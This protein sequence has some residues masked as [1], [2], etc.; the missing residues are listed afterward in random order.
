MAAGPLTRFFRPAHWRLEG[1]AR[2]GYNI[3]H[4]SMES[5]GPQT[6]RAANDG[7]SAATRTL[8]GV[9]PTRAKALLDCGVATLGDLMEYFP[10]TYQIE[11]SERPIAELVSNQ[12]QYAR[13][14]VTAVDYIPYP[15]P[16]F[17]ATLRDPT[18]ILSLTWFNGAYLRS[19]IH[20]GQI[21]RVKGKVGS[22]HGVAQ[23]VQPRWEV[24]APDA[25]LVGEDLIRAIYPA[26]AKLSSLA[27]WKIVDANIDKA[28]EAIPEWFP[29]D[30]LQSRGLPARRQAY[31][32]IHQPTSVAEAAA[33][34]RRLVYDELML[35]QLALC[36]SRR[37][38]DIDI[39]ATP[40]RLDR[41]LDE[42]IRRRFPFQLTEAQQLAAWQ[43]LRDM[44]Q[45]HPMNRLLQGDV[46]CGKT[47]VALYGMLAAV[48]NRCQA[49]VL[50]P[51]ETL[52]EQH[53][54]TI[55][56]FLKGSS[57]NVELFTGRTKRQ[58]S[59]ASL[60]RLA[61]G[62]LHIAVGTQ[63]LIQQDIEFANLGLVVVD[64]QHKLGVR[65]RGILKSKGPSP[66]YLVMTATP[67][68]RT[69]ALSYFADFD[70]T[71]I[72]QL[73]QGRQPITTMWFREFQRAEAV[74]V[75]KRE[76]Q[77]G[78]QAYIVVPQVE[79]DIADAGVKSVSAEYER[80]KRGVLADWRVGVL[81]GQMKTE[82]K[83]AAML[84]FR[85]HEIDVL[86]ATTVIEV[87]IDVANATVMMIENADRFGLSQLHQ[88]RGRVGR[89]DAASFCLLISDAPTD[90]A[91]ER[92]TA[93][94][95]TTS[96]FDI[97][98]IDLRLRG[99]GEFFGMRQHGLPEFKLADITGEVELL[100]LTRQDAERL[101]ENDPQLRHPTM[102]AVR[103][104]LLS[105]F[106]D[107]LRLAHIG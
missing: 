29:A 69:L 62:E 93:M 71:T 91:A 83:Q 80:L 96:G 103:Q 100:K 94:T 63:A 30:L 88:L 9:G 8:A 98:E 81:H 37:L 17:E 6:S 59:S 28:L 38:R 57:V 78:R 5:T 13:G 16:R 61:S 53:Y 4:S 27:I 35:M 41:T 22:F 45:P 89:G 84:A 90:D 7:L 106:S 73:P 50:A 92:L 75:L 3:R 15:R 68:P 101:L 60:A 39:Q 58:T 74:M 82:Q 79:Q 40:I 51:T 56:D 49:A 64:E 14:E 32:A 95:Q 99:P 42:R 107:S 76:L 65:Q 97:A 19:Q 21:L 77:A 1:W 23:M 34:R 47:V 44:Q 25:P 10:R 48:A 85:K 67:I 86:V 20:P 72:N 33:A 18:G 87:G 66:H 2:S 70:I 52:A 104:E 105:R 36:L 54:L 102:L 31:R 55:C 26:T 12:L 46:G 11:R 43:I 24:I